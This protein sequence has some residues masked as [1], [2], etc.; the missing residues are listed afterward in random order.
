MTTYIGL[1]DVGFLKAEGARMLGT[2]RGQVR[3]DAEAV[4]DWFKGL[5]RSIVDGASF[6]RTYW[7][8]GAFNPAHPEYLG[9][10]AYFDA[11]GFT[12]GV[13]LR[14][15]H[16]AERTSRLESQSSTPSAMRRP[17]WTSMPT[18]CSPSSPG[19]GASARNASRRAST[20]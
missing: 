12:P 15:G 6:V 14:L 18:S 2:R 5:D 20:R 13:Q 4:I 16:V 17:A 7:Y 11:I 3:P 19:T 8:D 9:Q 10:R 1:V